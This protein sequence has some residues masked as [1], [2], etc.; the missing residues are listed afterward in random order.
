MK[1][2]SHCVGIIPAR[3]QSTR[4]PGKPLADILGKP[5][6]WHVY[7]RA[8]KCPQLSQVVLATDDNRIFDTARSL[9]VAAVMTRPDHP[10]GTD[11][12]LEA[13]EKLQVPD[14]AVVVNIQGDEPLLDPAMITALVAPFK[15]VAIGVTTLAHPISPEAAENPNRVTVV[16]SKSGRGLYFSR[17]KLPY[18]AGAENHSIYGHIGLYAYRMSH[19]KQFVAL[20]PTLLE[21]V[22]RLEML[23]L[24][25][26]DIPIF[27]QFTDART[28]GVD[29]PDDL[30]R[31]VAI[32]RAAADRI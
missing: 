12:I 26:N 13:A 25:E 21:K 23:R 7:K 27:V 9:D 14:T 24:L 2:D 10:S 31:V 4:F 32:M 22:E 6:F 5:M 11:R 29:H 20:G 19:L 3:F 17:A 28:L 1:P 18:N 16:V 8:R 15:D 30:E